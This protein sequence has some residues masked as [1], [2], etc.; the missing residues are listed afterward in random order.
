[1]TGTVHPSRISHA[2]NARH[3]YGPEVDAA[4]LAAEPDVDEWE[5]GRRVPTEEQVEALARL[6]AYPVEWF[7]LGPVPVV[8]RACGRRGSSFVIRRDPEPP[9]GCPA[10]SVG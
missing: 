5:A 8:G 4:C 10:E 2:L 9:E 7:Y 1:M 3:L 6:T